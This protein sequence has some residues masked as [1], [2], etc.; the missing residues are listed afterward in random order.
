MLQVTT[1]DLTTWDTLL[2]EPARRLPDELARIDAYLDD[3]RF[4]APWRALFDQR[5]GRPSV[6]VPTVVRLLY[7]K[8]RYQ[9]GY[10]TLVWEVGDSITWRRFA[11]IPLDQPVP[12]PTTLVKLVGRAGPQVVEQLNTALVAKLAGDKLLR[13]R[14]LRIDTTVVAADIDYPTDADL[15]EHA[16]RKLGG[17]VSRVKARRAATR[18]RFRVRFRDRRRA[19][20]RRLH[21]LSQVLRRPGVAMAQIDQ[22]TAQIARLARQSVGEAQ[23][24]ARAARRLLGRRPG[25]GWLR[26]LAADLDATIG[27]TGRLLAQTTQRLAGQRT[28]TDRMVS[29]ADPDEVPDPQGQA[30][31]PDRVR[32]QA[33]GRPAGRRGRARVCRRPPPGAGQPARR[34]ATAACCRSCHAPDRPGC[35]HRGRRPRVRDRR[36]HPRHRR[37]RRQTRRAAPQGSAQRRPGRLPGH[38]SLPAAAHLAGRDR[39][40]HQP[41]QARLRAGP[42]PAAPPARR[43]DLGRAG[44]LRLQPAA[45]DGAD[46]GSMT[47][48]QTD[49]PAHHRKSC[50]QDFFRGK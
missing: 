41:P 2:P 11:R 39:G 12:H 37:P 50:Y 42:H 5:L 36:Q 35:G 26:R 45:H 28:I 44:D 34:S 29:L 48:N 6:P 30:Q 16:I 25:D 15:L 20:G 46:S 4:I 19:A 21:Q 27:G 23:E 24:V 8:H 47:S 3:E 33:A 22:L 31:S 18:V 13:G 38:Q 49:Q 10:Q 1:P 9:L 32:R 14:K 7:L 43:P 17:L 40:A